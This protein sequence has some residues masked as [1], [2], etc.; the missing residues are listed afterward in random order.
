MNEFLEPFQL[1]VAYDWDDGFRINDRPLEMFSHSETTMF[2]EG[3]FRYAVA[4]VT[5]IDVI[6]LEHEAPTDL[7]HHSMLVERL[8]KSGCQGF[9]DRVTVSVE[10]PSHNSDGIECPENDP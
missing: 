8:L 4:K 1:K 9:L 3:A 5:E 6:V 7:E 10:T 2:F